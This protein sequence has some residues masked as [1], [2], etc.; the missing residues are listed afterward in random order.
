MEDTTFTEFE[1]VASE[2][3]DNYNWKLNC[4]ETENNKEKCIELLKGDNLFYQNLLHALDTNIKSYIYI[5]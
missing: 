1:S 2:L 5:R 3:S 4:V